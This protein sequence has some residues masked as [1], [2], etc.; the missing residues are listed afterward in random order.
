MLISHADKMIKVN[1]FVL[2][3]IV[4]HCTI[5]APT[6]LPRQET[7]QGKKLELDLNLPP[8]QDEADEQT[9][10]HSH[11]INV[12]RT[13]ESGNQ[14]MRPITTP[15]KAC[16]FKFHRPGCDHWKSIPHDVRKKLY[17]RLRR[18]KR[19][20]EQMIADKA[21]SV[22]RS[23]KRYDSFTEEEKKAHGEKSMLSRKRKLEN[24]TPE[25]KRVWYKKNNSYRRRPA[26]EAL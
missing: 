13:D 3:T 19:T 16:D 8:P 25:E 11:N 21:S 15:V 2:V 6:N 14:R 26:K 24:M 4:L 9:S 18:E 12:H 20:E 23:K 10:L 7:E 1:L 22:I 17:Y 5:A